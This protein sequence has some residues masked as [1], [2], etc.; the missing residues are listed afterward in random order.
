[1]FPD[2]NGGFARLMVKTLIPD[3]FAG[4]RTVDAVWQ[5]RVNFRT[6]DRA[7]Q[8]TRIRLN[9]TVVRAEHAGNPASA[10]Y[11]VITYA[12][13]NRLSKVR[14]RSV[15]MAGGSWATKHVVRDLPAS[16]REAYAQFY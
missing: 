14:A 6:L 13:G 11:V 4:P 7:G 8:S 1:M 2:G 12:K 5:K 15:V 9:S 10:S 3:A 16:H